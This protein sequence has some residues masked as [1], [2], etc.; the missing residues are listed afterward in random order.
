MIFVDASAI[1][2]ILSG[3]AD[4]PALT[5]RLERT[6]QARTSVIAIYE[7]TLAIARKYAIAPEA[8]KRL[9]LDFLA[10]SKVGVQP[11]GEDAAI[12]ALDAHA[13]FGKGRHPAGLNMGDC[14]AYACAKLS[15]AALLYKGQDFDATDLRAGA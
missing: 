2:A 1:V 5:E 8:A 6:T 3:E 13:R 10:E 9:V 7:A 15:G 11:I 12:L 14:F 4:A